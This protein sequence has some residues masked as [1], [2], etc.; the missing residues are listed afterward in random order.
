MPEIKH[1]DTELIDW[2]ERQVVG[3]GAGVV[4]RQSVR[5][6][7]MRLHEIGED[8]YTITTNVPQP[9]VRQAITRAM[10]RTMDGEKTPR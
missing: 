3:Y 6:R 1:T 8:W 9:T 10:A 2:L 4:F 7:G 5:G